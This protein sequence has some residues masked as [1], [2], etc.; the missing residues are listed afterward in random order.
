MTGRASTGGR[1]LPLTL[2][3]FASGS[4]TLCW[5][6]LDMVDCGDDGPASRGLYAESMSRP[7][8]PGDDDVSISGK[9]LVI[10]RRP[11]RPFLLDASSNC[12]SC[13]ARSVE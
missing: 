1:L 5:L 7:P 6:M 8:Y 11:A 4:S 12:R 13:H 2:A 10:A 9:L 3:F